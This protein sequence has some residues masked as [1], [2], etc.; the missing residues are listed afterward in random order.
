MQKNKKLYFVTGNRDKFREVKPVMDKRGINLVHINL[1]KPEVQDS[2]ENVASYAAKVLSKKLRKPIMLE[3]TG[4]Y[5]AA[6]KDFPGVYAKHVFKAL[7]FPGLF[8]LLKGKSKKMYFKTVA[9][10]CEPGNKPKLFTGSTKGTAILK[11]K[12]KH[13]KRLPYDSIF[14]PD[15]YNKVYAEILHLKHL[16]SHRV[17]AIEKLAKYLKKAKK[18]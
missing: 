14:I 2:L 9:A 5:F 6:Y 12:G 7:G 15:G 10:Y 3:D 8:R 4:V 13:P 16:T 17:Q 1:D 11:V 18:F